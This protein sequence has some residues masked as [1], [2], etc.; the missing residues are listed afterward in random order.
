MKIKIYFSENYN[1]INSAH[2]SQ[3]SSFKNDLKNDNSEIFCVGKIISNMM[4]NNF[5]V[6][7]GNKKNNYIK[8]LEINYAINIF[9]LLGVREMKVDKY[10]NNKL[11][12]SLYN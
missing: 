4:R 8:S 7:S 5:I 3:V 9:G 10:I 6:Y 12:L 1:N 11:S 2:F